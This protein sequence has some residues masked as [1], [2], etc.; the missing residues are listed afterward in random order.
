MIYESLKPPAALMNSTYKTTY[1]TFYIYSRGILINCKMTRFL[2][3]TFKL[4]S[5]LLRLL[6]CD[7]FQALFLFRIE[8]RGRHQE[9]TPTIAH[10][11]NILVNPV[12]SVWKADL[13]VSLSNVSVVQWH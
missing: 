9:A 1:K 13:C 8:L 2:K 7:R 4:L 3:P 6:V 5:D 12:G 11:V 10:I